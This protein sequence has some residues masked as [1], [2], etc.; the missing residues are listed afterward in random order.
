MEKIRYSLVVPVFNEEAVI[1][2]TNRRLTGVMDSLGELYEII[3]V[4][5]GSRDRSGELLRSFCQADPRIKLLTFSRNFGH[6]TAITAGMDHASGDAVIVIDA[7]LQDP[8]E[9]IPQMPSVV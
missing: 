8:P 1:A 9:I 7:D 4:N 2:E 5:D 3:Y 6:Q